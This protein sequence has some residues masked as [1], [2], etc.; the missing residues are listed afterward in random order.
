MSTT[1]PLATLGLRTKDQV[2]ALISQLELVKE[3]CTQAQKVTAK[4]CGLLPAQLAKTQVLETGMDSGAA[5]Q[6]IGQVISQLQTLS[7]AKVVL[8]YWPTIVQLD[9]L[10]ALVQ[11]SLGTNTVL[12]LDVDAFL[13]AGVALE[14]K[15]ARSECSL[16]VE[17]AQ[18]LE[19]SQ[20]SQN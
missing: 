19:L 16:R 11:A 9:E 1:L 17:L 3:K 6:N 14:T 10:A 2:Q 18:Q 15:S 20:E 5:V 7:V 8:P 13:L 12:E 4:T